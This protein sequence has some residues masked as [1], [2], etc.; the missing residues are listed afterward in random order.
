MYNKSVHGT[1]IFKILFLIIH[2]SDIYT[3][4]TCL[5]ISIYNS[6]LYL[7]V[8]TILIIIMCVDYIGISTPPTPKL[9]F[10]AYDASIGCVIY[11]LRLGREKRFPFHFAIFHLNLIWAKCQPPPSLVSVQKKI[12]T[13]TSIS[14]LNWR[15]KIERYLFS[16]VDLRPAILSLNTL[17]HFGPIGLAVN[18]NILNIRKLLQHITYLQ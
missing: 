15:K 9:S 14:I 2:L 11:F 7:R 16:G 1:R 5:A 13:S 18:E 17:E 3:D 10:Y 6:N 8:N 4:T 12:H